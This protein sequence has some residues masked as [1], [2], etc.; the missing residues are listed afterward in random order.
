MTRAN[1]S[2]AAVKMGRAF[3]YSFVAV[4]AVFAALAILAA[5]EGEAWKAP[6]TFG[7]A[8]LVSYAFGR[9]MRYLIGNE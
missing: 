9:L 5:S 1:R 7:A 8:A 2:K 6:L 3:F 4:S